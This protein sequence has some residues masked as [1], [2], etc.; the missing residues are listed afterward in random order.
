[1]RRSRGVP[2]KHGIAAFIIAL[3][4]AKIKAEAIPEHMNHGHIETKQL[5]DNNETTTVGGVFWSYQ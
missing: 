4:K 5:K 2:V 3:K 1:M